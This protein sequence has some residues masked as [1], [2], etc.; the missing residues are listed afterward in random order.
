MDFT[1]FHF[2][3]C[4]FIRPSILSH[5]SGVLLWKQ[6]IKQVIPDVRLP[7]N[8]FISFWE[9]LRRSL[10]RWDM[11]VLGW[12]LVSSPRWTCLETSRKHQIRRLNHLNCFLLMP[13]SSDSPLS[14]LQMFLTLTLRLNPSILRTLC[15]ECNH[16]W[17]LIFPQYPPQSPWRDRVIV[18]V[19]IHQ[20]S[21][22]LWTDWWSSYDLL[23]SSAGSTSWSTVPHPGWIHVAPQEPKVQQPISASLPAPWTKLSWR[24]WVVCGPPF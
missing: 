3:R 16:V 18:L 19:Q 11:R 22:H 15:W 17:Y 5:F 24:D 23:S 1:H 14:F 7:G 12:T 6:K 10:V 20:T 4:P 2:V 21:I 8:A 13:R 9:I